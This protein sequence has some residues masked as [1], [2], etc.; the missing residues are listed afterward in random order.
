[1]VARSLDAP[2]PPSDRDPVVLYL[3]RLAPSSRRTQRAALDR[4]AGLVLGRDARAEDVGWHLLRAEQTVAIRDQLAATAAPTTTNRL[5]AALRGVLKE[6]WRL[7]LMDAER[8]HRASA[9]ENV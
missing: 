5:L 2:F 1:M 3:A 9:V 6:A 8:Y 7:G 4:I